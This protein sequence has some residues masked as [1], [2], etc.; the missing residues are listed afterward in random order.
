[1]INLLFLNQDIFLGYFSSYLFILYPWTC[2]SVQIPWCDGQCMSLK[3]LSVLHP[4][5]KPRAEF[6]GDAAK[7]R[8]SWQKSTLHRV[9]SSTEAGGSIVPLIFLM[10]SQKNMNKIYL[11]DME[12]P[13]ALVVMRNQ[14]L[15]QL[16]Q[17]TL[18][19]WPLLALVSQNWGTSADSLQNLSHVCT[20]WRIEAF[21]TLVTAVWIL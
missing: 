17:R 8:S 9:N 2:H 10:Q 3:E 16:R 18:C 21:K 7:G 5:M 12:F 4:V 6:C 11:E 13:P 19:F 1:M 20:W 15:V 14:I